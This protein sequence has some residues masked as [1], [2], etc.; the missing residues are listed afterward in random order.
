MPDPVVRS[1]TP[2]VENSQVNTYAYWRALD[3]PPKTAAIRANYPPAV[4]S[5]A[6]RLGEIEARNDVQA[7]LAQHRRNNRRAVEMTRD[8]VLSGLLEAVGVA[9]EQSDSRNMIAGW[10]EIAKVSG[11]GAP[12]QKELTVR[13]ENPSTMQLRNASDAELLAILGKERQLPIGETIEDAEF[14]VVPK[15]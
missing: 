15:D 14:S 9:R 2:V 8:H 11:V 7:A 10:A 13:H 4:F 1:S 5:S 12:E 6:V 3:L